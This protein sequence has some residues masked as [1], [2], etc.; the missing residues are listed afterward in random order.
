M[1]PDPAAKVRFGSLSQR[2]R[3]AERALH[4]V[5][6][7]VWIAASPERDR[8]I[9]GMLASAIETRKK[10][11]G[12]HADR[13]AARSLAVLRALG[14][15]EPHA[16]IELGFLLH[17]VGQI[18]IPESVLLKATPPSCPWP[19]VTRSTTRK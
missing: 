8:A 13:V 11:P 3:S 19:R 1:A 18:T 6:P 5:K 12:D 16:D 9:A 4:P 15:A 17:D 14:P 2:L 7:G 10:R